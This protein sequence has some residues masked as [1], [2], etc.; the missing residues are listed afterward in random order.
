MPESELGDAR[1]ACRM[2][3]QHDGQA[4]RQSRRPPRGFA[5]AAGSS[6]L[7]GRCT[8][9]RAKLLVRLE[10]ET[11]RARS[12][13]R[14]AAAPREANRSSRC[15]RRRHSAGAATRAAVLVPRSPRGEQ[16][17]R[18]R[19]GGPRGDLL[20][21]AAVEAS[22]AASTCATR[23]RAWRRSAH[24][25]RSEFTS[26]PPERCPAAPRA[27]SARGRRITSAVIDAC[28]PDPTSRR[29]SGAQEQIGEKSALRRSSVVLAV[30][31]RIE[32]ARQARRR[33]R[34]F[35][36][37]QDRRDLHGDWPRATIDR[38]FAI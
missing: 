35:E 32:A 33:A 1:G 13:M 11:T 34:S 27:G 25:Q 8:V 24:R 28:D 5:S 18:Q 3:G 17:V 10:A 15:R 6:T 30:C 38:I 19:V 26:R 4:A 29:W 2:G 22:Q 9:R 20:R 16:V 36:R 31:T 21:H 14:R 37:A 12:R 23:I 7:P